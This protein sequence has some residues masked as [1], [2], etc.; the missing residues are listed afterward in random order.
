MRA[1]YVIA[2]ALGRWFQLLGPSAT[3][4]CRLLAETDRRA[5][6]YTTVARGKQADGNGL[7]LQLRLLGLQAVR[8]RRQVS[9]KKNQH[10]HTHTHTHTHTALM[11]WSFVQD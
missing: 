2:H 8:G 10:A 7:F 3:P 4:P 9:I 1:R 6:L 11:T 5:A